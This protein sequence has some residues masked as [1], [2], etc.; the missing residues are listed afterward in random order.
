[1][2]AQEFRT[3]HSFQG[4]K[5]AV[6]ALGAGHAP[7]TFL[8]AG[9]EGIVVRWQLDRPEQGEAIV[10]AGEAVFSLHLLAEQERLLIGTGSGRLLA[11]DLRS[12]KAVQAIEAHTKGIFRICPIDAN[13]VACAG[14]DGALSTWHVPHER[15]SPLAPLRRIPLCDEKLRDIVPG[16]QRIAVAC[17]DGSV[18]ELAPG[19][20]NEVARIEGHGSGTNAVHYHPAKPVLLSGGKDGELRIWRSDGSLLHAAAAHKGS[21]YVVT[22][23]PSERWL[24][25]AGR[26]ALVKVWE[27]ATL[28]PVAR[29]ARDRS[30]HTHSVNAAIWCEGSLITASDDRSIRSWRMPV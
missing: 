16:T 21:V 14:G 28:D 8:S 24:V 11:I 29:S 25:T 2:Y 9:G 20:L 18:R 26:D 1:M 15:T 4:H 7:G 19:T 22:V 27:A 5:A 17:G 13:T 6:Y 30:G 3:S 23:D 12:G 10:N